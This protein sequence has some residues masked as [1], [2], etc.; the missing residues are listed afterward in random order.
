MDAE[1]TSTVAPSADVRKLS[2]DWVYEALND[3]VYP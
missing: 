3:V 1:T 2:E